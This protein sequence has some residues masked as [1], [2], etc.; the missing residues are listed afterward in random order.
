MQHGQSQWWK[1]HVFYKG[2]EIIQILSFGL[3]PKIQK[4][5]SSSLLMRTGVHAVLHLEYGLA[6]DGILVEIQKSDCGNS[7]CCW[8]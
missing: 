4:M 2:E 5:S 3:E 8:R 7:V 6:G 1:L